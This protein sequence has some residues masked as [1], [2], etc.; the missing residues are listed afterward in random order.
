MKL[1][2]SITLA[3]LTAEDRAIYDRMP[4]VGR[5]MVHRDRRDARIMFAH[6]IA[7]TCQGLKP[8]SRIVEY[9]P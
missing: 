7:A 8:S 6:A 9:K 5:L 3:R 2:K 1:H 4:F